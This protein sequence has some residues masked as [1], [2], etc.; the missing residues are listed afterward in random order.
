MFWLLPE[1]RDLGG[2]VKGQRTDQRACVLQTFRRVRPS[3]ETAGPPT[4][5]PSVF[6]HHFWCFPFLF[7]KNTKH[8]SE[9]NSVGRPFFS[10]FFFF[11][12][13]FPHCFFFSCSSSTQHVFFFLFFFPPPPVLH[14]DKVYNILQLNK[15]ER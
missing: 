4:F 7:I 13:F 8:N 10:I 6:R 3:K 1:H 14:I 5:S 12:F 2:Q 15:T 9:K 11:F